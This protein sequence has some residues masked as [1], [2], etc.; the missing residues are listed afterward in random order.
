[1]AYNMG[2]NNPYLLKCTLPE[3]IAGTKIY[4]STGKIE[5]CAGTKTKGMKLDD[6]MTILYNEISKK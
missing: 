3:I 6:A 4:T 2:A 1:M 5:S